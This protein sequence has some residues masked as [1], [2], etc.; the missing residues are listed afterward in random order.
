MRNNFLILVILFLSTSVFAEGYYSLCKQ[1]TGW[2][3]AVNEPTESQAIKVA[4]SRCQF[5]G[6]SAIKINSGDCFAV[7][8]DK[9]VNFRRGFA[10]SWLNQESAIKGAIADCKLHDGTDCEIINK[11][12]EYKKAELDQCEQ[13]GLTKGTESYAVC[14][15]RVDLDNKNKDELQKIQHQQEEIIKAQKNAVEMQQS[16]QLMN[17]GLQLLNGN[18]VTTCYPTPGVPN[19]SY[20]VK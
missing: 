7:A 8:Q 20:C 4:Q 6:T 1:S 10:I 2:G 12:C 14:V 19:S 13:Y 9:L 11:G 18:S 5:G 15:M 17:N 3:I 16:Q